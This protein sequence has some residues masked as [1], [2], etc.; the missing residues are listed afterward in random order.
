MKLRIIAA[1]I[2]VA[3]S[4]AQ[5]IT[6]KAQKIH[7]S[8]IIVDTHADTPQRF[9]DENYD[10]GCTDPKDLGHISLDKAKAGN[11]GAE[12]FSIWVDPGTV[13]KPD[14]AKHTLD[15]IDSVYE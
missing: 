15:E 4:L 3:P 14:F 6:P 11:L 12:F 8:A 7:D 1:L 2:L 10:I 13:A 9:L 5:T